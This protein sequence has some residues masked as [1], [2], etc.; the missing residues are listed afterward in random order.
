MLLSGV[1]SELLLYGL[2]LGLFAGALA[3]SLAGL[4]GVGGGLIYTPLFYALLP[5]E[6]STMA[7]FVFTSMVAITITGLF[8][9]RAHYRLGHIHHTML[10]LLLPGLIC[11]AALG[12]WGTLHIPAVVILLGLAT[13]EAWV[14]FD[15][16][17][18]TVSASKA[19]PPLPL[20]SLPIGYLSGSFGIAGGTMIVPLLRRHIALRLAVGT[21][22]ACGF[23]MAVA[24]TSLNL[25]FDSSWYELLQTQWPRLTGI[26]LGVALITPWSSNYAA[27]YHAELNENQLH[28]LLRFV[29]MALAAGVLLSVAWLMYTA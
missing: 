3:G 1:E 26:W 15:Y 13:I 12:L 18:K 4:A 19:S 14:A 23:I 11:G 7:L 28:S 25:L 10:Y 8:S 27:H 17:K 6:G 9:T 20:A 5:T 22:A 24:A 29:F 2:L 21:S 16:G